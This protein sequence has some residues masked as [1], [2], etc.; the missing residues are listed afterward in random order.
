MRRAASPTDAIALAYGPN[1]PP[2]AAAKTLSDQR[3]CQKQIGKG[4]ADFVKKLVL[5]HEGTDARPTPS[6][7]RASRSTRSSTSAPSRS[8]PTRSAASCCRRSGRNARRRS[9]RVGGTVD[10]VALRDCLLTLMRTWVDRVGAEPA[11]AAAE[12]PLHPHRRPALGHDRRDAR[13]R[14]APTSCRARA[15]SWPTRG[16]SSRNGFMTT[17]LCCPSRSSILHG[18]LRAPHRRLQERR[19]QRRR[20]R[21]RRLARRSRPGCRAPAIARA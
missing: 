6:C 10:A 1:N 3:R 16:S 13:H 8:P 4:V 20:R 21:L 17:P 5:H 11:A 9:G 7:G 14:R 15:P 2:P 12:H 19:Q 18:Q